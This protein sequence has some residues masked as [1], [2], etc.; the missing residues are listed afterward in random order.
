M[1]TVE[2]KL[3]EQYNKARKSGNIVKA[4]KIM[5]QIDDL[6]KNKKYQ[7]TTNVK[8]ICLENLSQDEHFHAICL[9]NRMFIFADI[10]ET[11]AIEFREYMKKRCD[12]VEFPVI[13]NAINVAKNARDITRIV[14]DCHSESLSDEFGEM[15]DNIN[16]MV[17][18]VIYKEEAGLKQRIKK[19]HSEYEQNKNIEDFEEAKQRA[20][21]K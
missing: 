7:E 4:V 3:K 15:C 17:M 18:N 19:E 14:D 9:M 2:E 5:K 12:I 20:F 1:K 21:G 11:A 16:N 6:N 10:L 8:K 13:E